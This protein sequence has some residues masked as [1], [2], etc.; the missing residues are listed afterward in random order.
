M[1]DVASLVRDVRTDVLIGH[2]RNPT[3][4]EPGTRNTHPFRYRQWLFAHTGTLGQYG[5]GLTIP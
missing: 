1:I 2:V 3:I 4:G 5:A